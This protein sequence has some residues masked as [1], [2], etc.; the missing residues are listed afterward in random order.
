MDNADYT[1]QPCTRCKKLRVDISH[2]T[3]IVSG[4]FESRS[5]WIF[6]LWWIISISSLNCLAGHDLRAIPLSNMARHINDV[7]MSIWIAWR[8]VFLATIP[9]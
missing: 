4:S 7:T 1:P 9:R 3:M 5:N 8:S 2:E 6:E